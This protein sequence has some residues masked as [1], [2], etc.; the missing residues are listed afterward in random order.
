MVNMYFGKIMY[1]YKFVKMVDM[2]KLL[3]LHANYVMV[4]VRHV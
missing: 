3:I 4:A 1:V 2:D